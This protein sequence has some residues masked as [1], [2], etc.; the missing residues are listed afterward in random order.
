MKNK[1]IVLAIAIIL[2]LGLAGCKLRD[3]LNDNY[4]ETE[5]IVSGEQLEVRIKNI[6]E[7]TSPKFVMDESLKTA[8]I[9][10][11][12]NNVDYV[13][14]SSGYVLGTSP[15]DNNHNK[16]FENSREILPSKI[17]L[18]NP[19]TKYYYNYNG[20]VYEIPME[21]CENEDEERIEYQ[22]YELKVYLNTGVVSAYGKTAHFMDN[23]EK[24]F[25]KEDVLK[26]LVMT[27]KNETKTY[28]PIYEFDLDNDLETVEFAISHPEMDPGDGEYTVIRP[29]QIDKDK[30]LKEFVD[31]EIC[32][33]ISNYRNVFFAHLPHRG[34]SINS[35]IDNYIVLTYYVYDENGFT[36]VQKLA[37][38][39]DWWD[40]DEY[41]EKLKGYAFTLNSDIEFTKADS[42]NY[43][44]VDYTTWG[45][46]ETAEKV[47]L[48]KGTKIHV[49]KILDSTG[50]SIVETL[51]GTTYMI[52]SF[53][54][55]TI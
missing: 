4:K 19:I 21:K 32:G 52:A 31:M 26:H 49:L 12:S 46:N 30:N 17:Y 24:I 10:K 41:T 18:N 51:D 23:S 38:G 9:L 11:D 2:V 42:D 20:E 27:S 50:N 25:G 36:C 28:M 55:M 15:D 54:G 6:N 3:N 35:L 40:N 44:K 22:D 53:A 48:P 47:T 5:N 45:Q 39:D 14:L 33:N 1:K 13:K 34:I 8:E 16:F 43:Y 29:L 37:N 7:V